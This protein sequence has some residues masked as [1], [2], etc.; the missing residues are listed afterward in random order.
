MAKD[1]G[2][3]LHDR[4]TRGEALTPDE[5]KRLEAWYQAMDRAEAAEL[6]QGE[7]AADAELAAQVDATLARIGTVTARLRELD[8]QIRALRRDNATLRSEVAQR[9][10]SQR[11]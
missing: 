11:A 8:S 6:G 2:P 5:Q 7:G 4:A 10:A 3:Q 1:L 9:L